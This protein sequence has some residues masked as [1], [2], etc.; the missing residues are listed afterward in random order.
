MNYLGH[1]KATKTYPGSGGIAYIPKKTALY[2]TRGSFATFLQ[3]TVW[4]NYC[5]CFE[6]HSRVGTQTDTSNRE[7]FAGRGN[8]GENE[9]E[10]RHHAA[11]L[12]L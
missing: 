9:K 6:Q 11:K 3:K 1:W 8:Y 2:V 7:L 4:L 5:K 10:E 12:P